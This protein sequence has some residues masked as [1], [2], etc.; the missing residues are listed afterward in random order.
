MEV[1]MI[2]RLVNYISESPTAFQAVENL[3]KELDTLGY[4]RLSEEQV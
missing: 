4:E 3:A 1:Y 2:N